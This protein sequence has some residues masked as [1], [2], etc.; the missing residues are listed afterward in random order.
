MKSQESLFPTFCLV[1]LKHLGTII[2]LWTTNKT[3]I[4]ASIIF[5]KKARCFSEHNDSFFLDVTEFLNLPVFIAV[6]T[7]VIF[8]K[9]LFYR[10][11]TSIWVSSNCVFQPR[12]TFACG[13]TALSWG[14]PHCLTS[15]EPLGAQSSPQA[16]AI[17]IQT[18]CFLQV[19]L[20][21]WCLYA[22]VSPFLWC[23]WDQC[24]LE[25]GQDQAGEE[26]GTR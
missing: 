26:Y 18:C 1:R 19:Q 10:Q 7:E 17:W 20:S 14:R 25:S 23:H 16:C 9:Y 2:T 22:Q 12:E 8:G 13:H 11:C 5:F 6:N 15:F 21:V 24:S 4:W 3:K